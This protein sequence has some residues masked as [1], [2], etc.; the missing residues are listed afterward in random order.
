V[1]ALASHHSTTISSFNF[2]E[3]LDLAFTWPCES[4]WSTITGFRGPWL[5]CPCVWLAPARTF[6]RSPL[7][8][9]LRLGFQRQLWSWASSLK[10]LNCAQV[11]ALTNWFAG[12]SAE[13][14]SSDYSFEWIQQSSF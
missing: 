2:D 4:E 7:S 6:C 5:I 13:T 10:L 12:W 9:A 14:Q 8:W 1:C 3:L 11:L